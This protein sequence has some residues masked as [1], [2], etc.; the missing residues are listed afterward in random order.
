VT[1]SKDDDFSIGKDAIFEALQTLG[2]QAQAQGLEVT[3]CLLGDAVMVVEYGARETTR[4]VDAVILAPSKGDTKKVLELVE[5]MA[6]QSG[7]PRDWLNVADD[8]HLVN[9]VRRITSN[10]LFVAPGIEVH[11]PVTTQMIA[12]NLLSGWRG[13][14][15]FY[16]VIRLI[17]VTRK[18]TGNRWDIWQD[19]ERFL[20]KDPAARSGQDL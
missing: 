20:P 10:C 17:K 18:I 2:A 12:L 4:R 19:V 14:A 13:D 7:W 1:H 9:E 5:I 16:D 15:D 11:V 8:G 3:L 6:E